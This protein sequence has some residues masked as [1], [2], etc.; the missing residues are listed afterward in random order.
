WQVDD[1]VHPHEANMLTL[2]WTKASHQLGWHP[3]LSLPEALDLTLDWYRDV[4]AGHN[5]R[6]KCLTQLNQYELKLESAS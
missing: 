3:L 1:G 5:A 2:D 4:Q 6:Q